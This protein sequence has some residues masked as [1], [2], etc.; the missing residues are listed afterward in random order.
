MLLKNQIRNH[1]Q[2]LQNKLKN[3]TNVHVNE[4]LSNPFTSVSLTKVSENPKIQ[5]EHSNSVVE[6]N[7]TQIY[8]Y[9]DWA[10][11]DNN[12]Y[13]VLEVCSNLTYHTT[14]FKFINM[15]LNIKRITNYESH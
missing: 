10:L 3:N 12:I 13:E 9:I 5:M 2:Y 4:I 7:A 6:P 15:F 14:T 1:I 11:Y 8:I